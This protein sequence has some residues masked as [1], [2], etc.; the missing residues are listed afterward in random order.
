MNKSPIL[1]IMAAGMGSRYGG[2]KQIDK[3]GPNGEI[4]MDYS[5]FDARRA[6]FSRVVFIIKREMEADFM[7]AIGNR[8]S[9]FFEVK[10]AYQESENLPNGLKIP[11]GRT[12][13]LG[14]AHAI[15]CTREYL[16]A[17]F[18]ALNADDYYGADGFA[19]VY[20]FLTNVRR[21][22]ADYAMIGYRIENTL[23]AHGSVSRGVCRTESEKLKDIDERVHICVTSGG[24]AYSLDGGKTF[25]DIPTGTPVSMNFW[26]FTTNII[27]QIEGQFP[28]FIAT[29]DKENPNKG[30]LFLPESVK[31][32]IANG[33]AEV[34]VF[35]SNDKWFGITYHEDREAVVGKIAKMTA[36]GKYPVPLWVK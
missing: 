18:A 11:D 4:L 17:P 3:L 25:I 2:P 32:V 36:E 20:K 35:E 13:P 12:K 34:S 24:Q 23:T 19:S 30:E 31:T 28:A 15:W 26:G 5:L 14:T 22:S 7:E 9:R 27:D 21:D 16:D 10:I 29:L 8:I 1:V 33:D 6:G